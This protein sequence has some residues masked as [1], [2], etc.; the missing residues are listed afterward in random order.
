V[1][2]GCDA[3]MGVDVASTVAVAAAGDGEMTW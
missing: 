2:N 3:E 1:L